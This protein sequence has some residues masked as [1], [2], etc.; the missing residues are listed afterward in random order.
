MRWYA[1]SKTEN[2]VEPLATYHSALSTTIGVVVISGKRKG[3]YGTRVK[4]PNRENSFAISIQRRKGNFF[5]ITCLELCPQ[6]GLNKCHHE[7]RA[8]VHNVGVPPQYTKAEPNPRQ[9]TRVCYSFCI[10]GITA[11]TEKGFRQRGRERSHQGLQRPRRH[12]ACFF[13][14]HFGEPSE[15][16]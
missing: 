3:P 15:G 11:V 14:D 9:S 5:S 2:T 4:R 8:L 12:V 6:M 16:F 7:S 1:Y 10:L 13:G